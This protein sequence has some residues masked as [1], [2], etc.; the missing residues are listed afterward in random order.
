M[1]IINYTISCIFISKLLSQQSKALGFSNL[2]LET[3]EKN[4]IAKGFIIFDHPIDEITI[5][6]LQREIG[7]YFYQIVDTKCK[8]SFV[9][10][11]TNYYNIIE[12]EYS[13]DENPFLIKTFQL[14]LDSDEFNEECKT[15]LMLYHN[16][17]V[18][19]TGDDEIFL[20]KRY[21]FCCICSKKKNTI[22]FNKLCNICMSCF[23]KIDCQLE[24]FA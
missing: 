6:F 2:T 21:D 15:S 18:H 9:K 4:K 24:L 20:C 12:E 7:I 23:I 17:F 11:D 8:F 13:H 3:H 19:V 10:I 1:K 5:N 16:N 22:Q 14:I